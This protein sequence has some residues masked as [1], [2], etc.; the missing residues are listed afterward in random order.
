MNTDLQRTIWC[1][2]LFMVLFNSHIN[3]FV[4]T[5][6]QTEPI[7][8]FAL[9]IILSD[10]MMYSVCV[11]EHGLGQSEFKCV[12]V[13]VKAHASQMGWNKTAKHAK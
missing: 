5:H 2:L 7:L 9:F 11:D 4:H 12:W 1:A 13:E 10:S 6:R 3:H 8:N